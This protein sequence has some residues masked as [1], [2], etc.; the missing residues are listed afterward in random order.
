MMYHFSSG[1]VPQSVIDGVTQL[2][3]LPQP[4]I[5]HIAENILKYLTGVGGVNKEAM[6]EAVSEFSA[7]A[8]IDI[9]QA[10]GLVK[11]LLNILK[12]SYRGGL[13]SAQVAEDFQ[14]LTGSTETTKSITSLWST[15]VHKSDTSVDAAKP[16][17]DVLPAATPASA[18]STK[19]APTAVATEA[20]PAPADGAEPPAEAPLTGL[21]DLL[22]TGGVRCFDELEDIQW[23]FGVTAASSEPARVGRTFVRLALHVLAPDGARRVRHVQLGVSQFYSLLHQLEKARSMARFM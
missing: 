10:Q 15:Y 3:L 12:A 22:E 13:T 11:I 20:G 1:E 8:G 5:T 23:R 2:A 19:P 21:D 17:A 4:S 14:K 18:V 7:T 9:G 16:S 6:A